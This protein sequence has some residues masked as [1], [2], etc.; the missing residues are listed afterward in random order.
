MDSMLVFFAC[1]L[2]LVSAQDNMF[3]TRGGQ[4][5]AVDTKIV[6]ITCLFIAVS[7]N[8]PLLGFT[9]AS[10]FLTATMTDG[11][12]VRVWTNHSFLSPSEKRIIAEHVTRFFRETTPD[13]KYYFSCTRLGR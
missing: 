3:W 10:P 2:A 13:L 11:S 1:W 7:T 12:K 5:G 9:D 4:L 6:V 8:A